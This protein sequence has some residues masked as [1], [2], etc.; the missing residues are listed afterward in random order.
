MH[1]SIATALARTEKGASTGQFVLEAPA[2]RRWGCIGLPVITNTVIPESKVIL[3]DPRAAEICYFGPPQLITDP[4]SG[5]SSTTG[6][7]TVIVSNYVD[8]GD[9]PIKR[10]LDRRNIEQ[11]FARSTRPRVDKPMA[12]SPAPAEQKPI[13][14]DQWEQIAAAA[15]KLIDAAA[16]TSPP[17]WSADRWAGL[18]GVLDLARID[19]NVPCVPENGR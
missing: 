11:H 9:D 12:V 6:N 13:H 16:W 5:S 18:A 7:T 19:A 3:L 2:L 10:K 1:P 4:F 14:A 17:P 15:N 8:L